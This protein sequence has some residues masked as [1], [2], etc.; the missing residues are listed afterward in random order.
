MIY[1]IIFKN[2]SLVKMLF[3]IHFGNNLEIA[4]M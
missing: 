3:S 1:R 4:F 2:Y